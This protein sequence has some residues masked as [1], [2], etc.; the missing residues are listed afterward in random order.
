MRNKVMKKKPSPSPASN[1]QGWPPQH[2]IKITILLK[3]RINIQRFPVKE[4]SSTRIFTCTN[5]NQ[6]PIFL[7]K[8]ELPR[9]LLFLDKRFGHMYQRVHLRSFPT[10]RPIQTSNPS[11]RRRNSARKPPDFKLESWIAPQIIPSLWLRGF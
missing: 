5:L 6:E 11:H 7:S 1:L 2:K 10:V 3:T 8:L 4:E 9:S